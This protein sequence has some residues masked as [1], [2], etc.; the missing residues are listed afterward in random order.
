MHSEFS[1][2]NLGDLIV[3]GR[4][5]MY[6]RGNILKKKI[7]VVCIGLSWHINVSAVAMHFTNTLHE[8]ADLHAP[9][10]VLKCQTSQQYSI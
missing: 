2:K 1:G 3:D 9:F 6:N 8:G 4:V 7:I 5:L 10:R